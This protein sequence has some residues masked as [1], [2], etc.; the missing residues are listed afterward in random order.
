MGTLTSL[1]DLSREALMADQNAL[2]IT[3]NNVSN[4]NTPGYTREVVN[5]QPTDAVTLSGTS[6]STG[7]TSTAT[8]VR[9]RVLEQRVQQQTQTQA[10]SGAL[11]SALQQVQDIFGLSSTSTS[12]SSTALGSAVDS[13]FNS[14]STLEGSPGDTSARQAVL[15]AANNLT[16]AFNSASNQLAQVSTGLDQQVGTTVGQINSLTTT[17][18]SLNQ[19][20]A[21]ISPNTDAG[22]LE[23]QRQLAIAQLSQYVGLDQM[24]TE[25]N[26]ITLTTANG[27]VLVSGSQSY[28]LSTTQVAGKTDVVANGQDVTS[29]ITGGQLG[30][31]LQAR[32]QELPTYASALDNLAYGIGTAVNQQ[33][34][35]GTDGSGNPGGAIFT[36]PT[37]AAGAALSIQVAT[38]DPKA[39]AAAATGEG[40]SGSGN[41]IALADLSTANVAGGQTASGFLASFL[42][43]VGNDAAGATTDNTA[44]QATLTQLTSQRDSLSGV[45]LDEEASNL[46]QY[47]RSYEAAAK[48]F[49]IVDAIM[50]SALNL[51]VETTVT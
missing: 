2:N 37:S 47:Q 44:Q 1:M 10:Q 23:D 16:S 25:S 50:A 43:Q 17:I 51:G 35:L 41:A 9:D 6:Y 24:T 38:S 27:A 36:L 42:G 13:F 18:A 40:S 14:L 48:V 21:T 8:S 3:A 45:S 12:A 30:G 34:A 7:I 39:I 26:G 5:W 33:N 28:A 29:G 32:D 31:V 15:T 11:Q 4:Q 19:Q 46:T 22:T 20:I 49:S